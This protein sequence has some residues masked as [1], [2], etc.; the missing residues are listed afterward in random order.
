MKI[1]FKYFLSESIKELL[2]WD[3][4]FPKIEYALNISINATIGYIPFFL[5]YGVHLR[6][7]INSIS[8]FYNNAE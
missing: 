6:S 5:L 4:L 7:E 1:I 3:E 8:A 2:K